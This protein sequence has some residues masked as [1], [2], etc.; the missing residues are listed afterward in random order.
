MNDVKITERGWA[1]H[2]IGGSR[3]RFHRNTL[4]EYG[5]KRWIVSTVGDMRDPRTGEAEMIGASRWY[6]TMAFEA[7]DRNGYVEIDVEKEIPISSERGLYA[8]SIKEL[9]EKYPCIDNIANDMH[10]AVVA[11]LIEKIKKY[12]M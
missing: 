3:C 7:E 5:D 11:E 9:E 8:G 2:F 10:D 6:E 1:G 4:L 12:K